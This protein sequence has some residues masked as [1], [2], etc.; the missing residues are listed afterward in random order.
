MSNNNR[1]YVDVDLIKYI[2]PEG[3]PR[4]SFIILS[5]EAGSGKS[6]L[7]TF[8][9]KNIMEQGE[10]VVFVA[11][12][13]DPLTI[14]QQ[15]KAF[16]T[17]IEEYHSKGLFYIVDGFTY[18]FSKELEK[19]DEMVALEVNPSD[20]DQTLYNIIKVLEEHKINGKGVVIID[21]LNV[22]LNYHEPSRVLEAVKTL[23]ANISKLRNVVVLAL[24]HTSTDYYSEF[25][26]SIVHLVDGILV[27]EVVVQHPMSGEIPLPLRQILV[28]KMKGVSHRVSWT[29]YVIDKEGIRPVI[30]KTEEEGKSGEKKK[31]F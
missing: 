1:L 15:F 29:L 8:I 9:A 23:R 26:N 14:I 17:R 12:D 18:L 25:L 24:L 16:S 5:G 13:D 4:N 28:K 6:V 27:T 20:L 22:F 19:F 11:F 31:Q 30:L 2:L 7:A 21:S 10:P 3:I